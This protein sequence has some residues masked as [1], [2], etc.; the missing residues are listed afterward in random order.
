VKTKQAVL[1]AALAS[2][3]LTAAPIQTLSGL[4]SVVVYEVTSSVFTHTFAPGSS[5][6]LNRV[7]GTLNSSNSDF[8][9]APTEDYDVFYS[10]S[11]GTPNTL[12]SFITIEGVYGASGSGMNIGEVQLTFSNGNPSQFANI[13]TASTPG[14]T[15]YLPGNLN[16]AIDG[17]T[18]TST[19]MGQNATNSRMSIT[20]GFADPP[21]SGVP[22]PASFVLGAAGLASVFALRRRH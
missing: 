21:T 2:L 10:D 16:N 13:L 17:N 18:A 5:A 1:I 11:N 7:S 8:S 12:G 14:V 3:T 6:L 4:S 20:V 9:G 22:E 15:N 19:G